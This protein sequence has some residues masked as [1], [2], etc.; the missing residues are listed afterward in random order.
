MLW[1]AVGFVVSPVLVIGLFVLVPDRSLPVIRDGGTR[2]MVPYL[3]HS[4]VV[5]WVRYLLFFV[6]ALDRWYILLPFAAISGVGLMYVL[7]LPALDEL[8]KSLFGG[9]KRKM[10]APPD[11]L[12]VSKE[13]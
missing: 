5:M 4:Y 12:T 3:L 9:L 1:R 13:K 10:F 8:Y 6:P 7:G 11:A 2:T